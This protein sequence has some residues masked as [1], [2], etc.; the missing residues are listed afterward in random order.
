MTEQ[1]NEFNTKKQHYLTE[2]QVL[3]DLIKEKEKII[4]IIAALEQDLIEQATATKEKG[5]EVD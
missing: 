1:P 3:D 5:A 4:N 2:K